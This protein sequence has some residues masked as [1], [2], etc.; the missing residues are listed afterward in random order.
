MA[1]TA[2]RL[3]LV[4][5]RNARR[6]SQ[7][8]ATGRA[9]FDQARQ[10]FDRHLY[11]AAAVAFEQSDWLAPSPDAVYWAA[12]AYDRAGDAY[13]TFVLLKVLTH[14]PGRDTSTF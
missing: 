11:S 5:W 6:S 12:R 7:Q 14:D 4:A 1:L 9:L 3:C 8:R 2:A 10:L 13:S